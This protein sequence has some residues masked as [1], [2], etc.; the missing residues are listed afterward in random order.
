MEL[1]WQNGQVVMQSQNHRQFRKPPAPA[2]TTTASRVIPDHRE[3]RSTDADNYMNQHLFMQED[4]MA[5]WLFDSMNEVEDPPFNRHDFSSETLFHS[6]AGS[7][8]QKHGSGG[9]GVIQ[10]QATVRES[11]FVRQSRPAVVAASRPPIHPA[12]KPEMVVNRTQNF[13]HFTNTNQRNARSEPGAS[14]SSMIAAGRESTVVDSCD[15]PVMTAKTYAASRLSETIRSATAETGCVS[16]STTGKAATTLDMTVTSSP[17]C[18][19][20]SAEPV[21]REPELDRKRKG[22]EPAESEFLSEVSRMLLRRFFLLF[23]FWCLMFM[24]LAIVR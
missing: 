11:E 21:H 12:R 1:L 4:E 10:A 5:S 18:S 22:R 14:S 19:S 13:A 3:I 9:G 16:V 20:G 15:T 7:A 6:S 17:G 24:A 8:G 2:T 23:L